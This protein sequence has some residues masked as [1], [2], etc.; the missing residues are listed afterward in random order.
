MSLFQSN[1]FNTIKN[2]EA[3][4]L[5]NMY[6]YCNAVLAQLKGVK[7]MD[8][9]IATLAKEADMLSNRIAGNEVTSESGKKGGKNLENIGSWFEGRLTKFI[10]GDEETSSK[11]AN[12]SS[13]TKN[14]Q[15]GPFT[16]YSAISSPNA[17]PNVT[18]AASSYDLPGQHQETPGPHTY[19]SGSAASSYRPHHPS[20]LSS[21]QRPSS[22]GAH[23]A[24]DRLRMPELTRIP[25]V[26]NETAGPEPSPPLATPA[27]N[28]ADSEPAAGGASDAYEPPSMAPSMPSWGQS[29][30]T[31]TEEQPE[32]PFVQA[33]SEPLPSG[34][35]IINPMQ[36]FMT[37]VAPSPSYEPQ[38]S[39]SQHDTSGR[40]FEDEDDE[41]DLGLGNASTRKKVQEKAAHKPVEPTAKGPA[42]SAYEP[43]PKP[44]ESKQ[45]E[46]KKETPGECSF[47]LG[48]KPDAFDPP[49]V[50]FADDSLIL[51]CSFWQSSS[52]FFM[53]RQVVGRVEKGGYCRSFGFG[54]RQGQAR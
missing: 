21:I 4:I 11:S 40:A 10:A 52:R 15:V 38:P 37:S 48:A 35:G 27:T 9:A 14:A 50:F 17:T 53:A 49:F 7:V 5:L 45:D 41:D 2:A 34:E 23:S 20:Q 47:L 43:A 29:Y 19:R 33:P 25:S 22:A 12:A 42:T 54:P 39:S 18:R 1:L 36:A 44:A 32:V 3:V 26:S 16:H 28:A 13:T 24:K 51:R 6:S 46:S 8:N 31:E 30:G